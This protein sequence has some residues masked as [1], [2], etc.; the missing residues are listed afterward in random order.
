MTD[1]EL[2]LIAIGCEQEQGTPAGAAAEA[3]LIANHIELDGNTN[4]K[5]ADLL[6]HLWGPWFGEATHNAMRTK[7]SASQ[8]V[9][10]AVTSVLV[11][12][13]R[14]LPGYID[15]HDCFSDIGSTTNGSSK[16]DRSTY[17]Q[18]ETILH[19]NM[20]ATYTFYCFPDENSDPFGYTSEDKRSE[21]GDFCYDFETGQPI[22]GTESSSTSNSN[23][24]AGTTIESLNNFL[25]IGDSILGTLKSG[26]EAE[27]AKVIYQVSANANFYLGKVGSPSSEGIC[28][29]GQKFD[30]D[31]NISSSD[32]P[33]GIYLVL[34]QNLCDDGATSYVD[35]GVKEIEELVE[36]LQDQFPNVPIFINSVLPVE[37]GYGYASKY[38]E[39]MK[40]ANQLLEDYCSNANNVTYLY[41]LEGFKDENSDFA[42]DGMTADKQHP[43]SKGADIILNN[44]KG[45]VSGTKTNSAVG[46]TKASMYAVIAT[47][48][49]VNGKMTITEQKV[50]YQLETSKYATPVEFLI[51]HL[52]VSTDPQYVKS[53]CDMVIHN[54]KIDY[55][56]QDQ[57]NKT[58]TKKC[59]SYTTNK[60]KVGKGE[61]GKLESLK[62]KSSKDSGTIV[63]SSSTTETLNLVAYISDADTWIVK[64]KQKYTKKVSGPT[65]TKSNEKNLGNGEYNSSNNTQIVNRKEWTETTVYSVTYVQS[66]TMVSSSGGNNGS[67]N[68]NVVIGNNATANRI[69][70]SAQ[71]QLGVPYVWGGS[72]P[73]GFDCSGL[74]QWCCQQAGANIPPRVTDDYTS[75]ASQYEVNFNDMQPGDVLWNDHHVGIY[76]GDGKFIHAPQ[77]GDVVKVSSVSAYGKFTKAYRFW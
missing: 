31:A 25:F 6:E 17:V 37:S 21:I 64:N 55:T 59:E 54:S 63:K 62:I 46:S 9:I 29:S 14:T 22:N 50:D 34:G 35:N 44:I 42:N 7:S 30:W 66:T 15:E 73:S 52:Q 19:N 10:D 33:S 23:S 48:K 36:K 68:S 67:N 77:T 65:T 4:G 12:G 56:I 71:S 28:S 26:L 16:T 3:S 5:G 74:V 61:G 18:Y 2:R 49:K 69:M 20:G 24:T 38:S 76:I 8:E 57:Y 58:T 72:S 39:G 27:G 32:S 47:Y 53:I 40:H 70:T 45:G 60:Y 41:T 11:D 75:S 43:N 13:K 1:E 51:A